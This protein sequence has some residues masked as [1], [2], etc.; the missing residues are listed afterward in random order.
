[1]SQKPTCYKLSII[2]SF[3]SVT[4]SNIDSTNGVMVTKPNKL[5]IFFDKQTSL[6]HQP[7]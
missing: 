4:F 1:M 3:K 7:V 5:F 2:I 6:E